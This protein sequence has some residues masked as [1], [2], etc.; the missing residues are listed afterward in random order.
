MEIH[1][2]DAT[3]IYNMHETGIHTLSNKPTKILSKSGKKQVGIISSAERG[4]L[5]TI[6]CCY[7]ATGFFIPPFFIYSRKKISRRLLNGSP[8][9]TVATCITDNG[10]ANGPKFLDWLQHFVENCRPTLK[11]KVILILDNHESH[12]E[13]LEYARENGVIFLS[14]PPHTTHCMQ[15]LYHCIYGPFETYFEQE[16]ST[17]QRCHVGRVIPQYDVASLVG[18]AYLR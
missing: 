14:L 4:K 7:N 1:G 12:I 6:I 16:I 9:G 2:I 11:Q 10:W 13:A 5:T 18:N 3:R 8:L 17:F 15:P